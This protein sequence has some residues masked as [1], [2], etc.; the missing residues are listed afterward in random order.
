MRNIDELIDRIRKVV[1]N[2]RLENEGEYARFLWQNDACD[3]K[4]GLNE[5][6][7]ADAA[8]ILYTI[9][10]FV[11]ESP[12]R[13]QWVK[14]LQNFQNPVS[15]LF[16]EPTHHFI[17]TTAHCVAAL[18]LFDATPKFPLYELQKYNDKE[19]LCALLNDTTWETAPWFQ[20]HQGAGI[21]A[22]LK[23]AG[24][25]K[26]EWE[27]EYFNWLWENEDPYTGLWKKGI[28]ENTNLPLFHFLVAGFHYLF[29]M[30]YAKIPLRYPDKLIDTCLRL[31]ED[32][33]I[34]DLA[35][36]G[37]EDSFGRRIGFLEID[38]IYC[39]TRAGRQTDYRFKDRKNA[40]RKFTAEY[41]DWLYSIDY[42]THDDFNDLH[43]LFGM[44]CALAEL[45]QVLK[46][47]IETKRPLRLVLDRRPFI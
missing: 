29:N 10:Y 23:L 3:R 41:L 21:Y 24:E 47:E 45:Q 16:Q 19:K 25:V 31:Y 33:K 6:G 15:G 46:G 1:E 7:C 5:Y 20:A 17:H 37:M 27:R 38:W 39:L 12:K 18:E 28:I 9:N 35:E 34:G 8:N 26:T 30:E 11:E 44:I 14:T 13:E 22:A 42:T 43:K 40:L 32:K 36:G 2:H 4:M